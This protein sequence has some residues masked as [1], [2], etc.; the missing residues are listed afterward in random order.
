MTREEMENVGNRTYNKYLVY[1]INLK[2]LRGYPDMIPVSALN[3][4]DAKDKV[5]KFLKS[6]KKVQDIVITVVEEE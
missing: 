2:N 6:T 3:K 4:E 1:Y 5:L